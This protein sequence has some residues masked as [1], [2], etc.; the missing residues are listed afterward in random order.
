MAP[1]TPERAARPESFQRVRRVLAWLIVALAA[2]ALAVGWLLP[3]LGD[4]GRA[5]GLINWVSFAVR[6]LTPHAGVVLLLCTLP[7]AIARVW[8]PAAAL[9]I[10]SVACIVPLLGF[11]SSGEGAPPDGATLTVMTVNAMY[12]RV[13]DA[14][15]LAEI[16]RHSP[17]VLVIQEYTQPLHS[18][19]S[20]QL[21]QQLPHFSISPRDDAFGMAVYSKLPFAVIPKAFPAFTFADGTTYVPPDPQ[22]RVVVSVAGREVVVQGVH[23]L[24]PV[25]PTYL[26]EQRRLCRALAAYA[27][28]ERRP[29]VL[30]GDFNHTPASM[31]AAWLRDA[32][33]ADA[34]TSG[35]SGRGLTWPTGS[36]LW[37]VAGFRL[38]QVLT[39]PGVRVLSCTTGAEIGSDHRPVIARLALP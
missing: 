26:A 13:R 27:Q 33:L 23:T 17:D 5:L 1:E 11:G 10:L 20:R 18:R 7:I 38:D 29:L 32:G 22:I 8:R 34:H 4:D 36:G 16:E 28:T 3:D 12:G 21:Q 25:R 2:A 14:D 30:A 15:L 6:T 31:P 9:A 37:A 39:S 19:V 24:P 35:G